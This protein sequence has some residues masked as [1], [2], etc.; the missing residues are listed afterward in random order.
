M[1]VGGGVRE[2]SSQF[3]GEGCGFLA[4]VSVCYVG[5]LEIVDREMAQPA[6]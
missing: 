2:V 3:E 5:W 1:W 6:V 4:F